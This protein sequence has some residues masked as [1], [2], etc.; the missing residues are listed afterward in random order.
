MSSITDMDQDVGEGLSKALEQCQA[1]ELVK[2]STCFEEKSEHDTYM[3]E[4]EHVYCNGCLVELFERSLRDESL[5]PPRCCRHAIPF[6]AV[7]RF[8]APSVI[9][10]CEKKSVERATINRTYC[11]NAECSTFLMPGDVHGKQASC[12]ECGHVT[13]VECKKSAHAGECD[14][15]NEGRDEAIRVAAENGWRACPHCHN[16]IELRSGC[17]HIT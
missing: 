1:T 15:F 7:K 11:F 3:T 9:I 10:G 16:M 6:F 2:C 17:N 12:P 14:L 8:F 5:F 13:C 4:C